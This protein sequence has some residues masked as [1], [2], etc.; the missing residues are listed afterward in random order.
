MRVKIRNVVVRVYSYGN[1]AVTDLTYRLPVHITSFCESEIVN[2]G[3]HIR[4]NG[5]VYCNITNVAGILQ[6]FRKIAEIFCAVG[7]S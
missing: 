6:Y 3:S 5:E 1:G 2:V 4:L 7:D